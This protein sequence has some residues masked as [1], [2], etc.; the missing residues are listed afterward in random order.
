MALSDQ[1]RS[2][3][4]P[5]PHEIVFDRDTTLKAPVYLDGALVA[6]ASGTITIYD[7]TNTAIV[8]AAAVTVSGSIAEYSVSANTFAEADVSERVRVEWA[9]VFS[10]VTDEGENDGLIVRRSLKPPITMADIYRRYKSLDPSGSS[11]ITNA[12]AAEHQ[13]KL[14]EAWVDLIERMIEDGT[15]PSWVMSPSALARPLKHLVLHLIWEDMAS[16]LN[17]AYQTKADKAWDAY[18]RAYDRMSVL[19]DADD[20]GE[21]DTETRQGVEP[22]G[23]WL[24]AG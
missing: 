2:W 9:L 10:G 5:L 21:A 16:R 15:R 7:D 20:D 1:G 18:N 22:S 4:F 8:S 6:P 17:P 24:G 11:A 12:T 14:D 19:I 23:F 3:R 13:E